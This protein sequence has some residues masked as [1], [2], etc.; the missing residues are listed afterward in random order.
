MKIILF[1]LSLV[2]VSCVHN[3]VEEFYFI[4]YSGLKQPL[5]Q[6]PS[7]TSGGSGQLLPREGGLS[8]PFYRLKNGL[9]VKEADRSF[10]IVYT[11][12]CPL[13]LRMQLADE[14]LFTELPL[15]PGREIEYRMP[16][17]QNVSLEGFQLETDA[18]EGA[19]NI[20]GT[21]VEDLF[22]G[23]QVSEE[24]IIIGRGVEVGAGTV[25]GH[26]DLF[27]NADLLGIH[28]GSRFQ[29]DLHSTGAE[30][31]LLTAE[32]EK[33][34]RREIRVTPRE[35]NNR[36]DL[37]PAALGFIPE[38]LQIRGGGF[39][40]DAFGVY[41]PPSEGTPLSIDLASLRQYPMEE[42][43]R[44][45]YEV[46]RW[47][48]VPQILVFDFQDYEVQAS[49]LKRLAFFVEKQGFRG[50]LLSE[51]ELEGR[52]GWNAHD[53][54]AEDLARFFSQAAAEEI[55]LNRDEL[56]L[57][58][59]LIENGIIVSSSAG[60]APLEGGVLSIS[61]ESDEYLRG[62]F[63]THEGFHGLFFADAGLRRRSETLWESFAPEE[64]EFWRAFLSWKQYDPYDE[65]LVVNELQ[66][67]LLQQSVRKAEPYYLD[68]TLPRMTALYPPSA[69]AVD[70]L[71][72]ERPDHFAASAAY[73]DEYLRS[74]WGLRAGDLE[75]LKY[76]Q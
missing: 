56:D 26:L 68:Y 13:T 5:V 23:A 9:K 52:H 33:G 39:D 55:A 14:V 59:I 74:A 2:L 35:G 3:E 47:N 19:L 67:Y 40:L 65:Y 25:D 8:T 28:D 41:P 6:E 37:Y 16:L 7:A 31:I 43:R 66:A 75:N 29:L 63:L 12:N 70:A 53:Y 71:L 45:E 22:P 38:R 44:R 57:R 36:I 27:M 60:Y 62:L 10:F 76:L 51:E 11:A 48:L 58:R 50:T 18:P 46:F 69:A 1:L 73:L 72:A 21:G 24:L 32:G 17:P 30:D 64:K 4:E 42:W 20:L 61:R 15:F 34:L 54:R 49:F